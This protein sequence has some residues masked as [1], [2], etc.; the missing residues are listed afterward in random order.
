MGI[1][2]VAGFP[3]LVL[4]ILYRHRRH[5]FGDPSDPAVAAVKLKYGFLYEVRIRG[6][7]CHCHVVDCSSPTPLLHSL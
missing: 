4:G 1:V 3:I 5:L 7:E 2:Y 6:W